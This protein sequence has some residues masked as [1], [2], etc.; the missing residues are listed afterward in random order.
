MTKVRQSASV[1]AGKDYIIR[2]TITG[3]DGTG[4]TMDTASWVLWDDDVSTCNAAQIV[5]VVSSSLIDVNLGA[6]VTT[7]LRGNYRTQLAG[8]L[9]GSDA[10][11]AE[12]FLEILRS[13]I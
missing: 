6:S 12:G 11:L 9:S 3:S 5:G 8:T 4:E 1:W 7:A 10:M 13:N 2:Y